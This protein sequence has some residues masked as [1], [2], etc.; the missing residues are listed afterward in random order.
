MRSPLISALFNPLNLATL[1]L[2]GIFGLCAAWW[3]F[4]LG[5]IVWACMVVLTYRDPAL[6]LNQ[7]L[8]SRAP[9]AQR[10]QKPFNRIQR[11]QVSLFNN[12]SSAKPNIRRSLEPLQ[13]AVNQ[14]TDLAY[15]LCLRMTS[16]QNYYL[17]TKSSRDFEGELF[18]NKVKMDN[19]IDEATRRD[20]EESKKMLQEQAHNFQQI[21]T[22]L[23]R[24]E[25]Q[26]GNVSSTIDNALSDTL[27]LQ[28]LRPEDISLEL[29]SLLK[30]IQDQSAQLSLFEKEAANSKL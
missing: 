17:V 5:L 30:P 29:P 20:Y 25:A 26:L 18:V 6:H 1:A 12:L 19:T 9:L 3:L 21:S 13:D 8:Q 27:R 11:S 2:A 10:F 22:L 4:P 15:S 28:A 16:L 14:L 7:K 24:V 23:D